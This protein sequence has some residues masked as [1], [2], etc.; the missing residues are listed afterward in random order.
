MKRHDARAFAV[1][2]CG[3][4]VLSLLP[5]SAAAQARENIEPAPPQDQPVAA[6]GLP[7]PP[8]DLS[9]KSVGRDFISDAGDIWTYP[10]SI[11]KRDVLPLLAVALSAALLIPNDLAIHRGLDSFAIDQD[12]DD[13]ISPIVSQMGSYGAW[14]AVGAFLGFGL[15]SKDHKAVETAALAASA[16]LQSSLVVRV[17][18]ILTGRLRP[19]ASDGVDD[20]AGPPGYF[21]RDEAGRAMSYDSFPSGHTATA[22]SL[23]TVV[24][25]QYGSHT[26]VPIAAYGV[27]AAVG[28][29]RLT[30]NMHW[31][32]DVVFGAVLGHVIGRLVVLNHRRRHHAGPSVAFGPGG[33]TFSASF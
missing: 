6:A 7:V 28:V 20:W 4:L 26:W 5:L 14:S 18:K 2:V 21:R 10:A 1:A 31:L 16:M 9:L 15:L 24:A 22:F 32:S 8:F 11:G 33:L 13:R 29:S 27:A 30:G 25:M 19:Y 3:C 12:G 23:A 17:G